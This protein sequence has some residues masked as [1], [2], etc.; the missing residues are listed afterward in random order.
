M[1]ILKYYNLCFHFLFL[2]I[3]FQTIQNVYGV[4]TAVAGSKSTL[5]APIKGV[6]NDNGDGTY[7]FDYSVSFDGAVTVIVELHINLLHINK[8]IFSPSKI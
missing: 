3:L 1:T 2:F 5:S 6:M 7:S 4:C 8:K